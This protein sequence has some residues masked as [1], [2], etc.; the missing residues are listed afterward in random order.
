M[1]EILE[2]A[3]IN[4]KVTE[5]V[6][7]QK[8]KKKTINDFFYLMILLSMYD[9][10]TSLRWTYKFTFYFLHILYSLLT[11]KDLLLFMVTIEN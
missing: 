10:F 11:K 4:N 6:A 5:V 9:V 7:I 1:S 3:T 2:K 8:K